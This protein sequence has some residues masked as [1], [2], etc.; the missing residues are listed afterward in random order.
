MTTCGVWPSSR[1]LVAVLLDANR[2]PALRALVP[3]DSREARWGL[4]QRLLAVGADLVVDDVLLPADALPFIALRAGVTVWVASAPLV[5][6]LR[7][8]AA[9][10]RGPPRST[11]A[12]LARLPSIPWLR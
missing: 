1:G 9:I 12:L 4:V 5:P 3:E 7:L 6:S 11:A 8:A 10:T 2:R